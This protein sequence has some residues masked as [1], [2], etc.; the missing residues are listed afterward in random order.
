MKRER[1]YNPKQKKLGRLYNISRFPDLMFGYNRTIM[2][3]NINVLLNI[4]PG[5]GA[6]QPAN[7]RRISGRCF[8]PFHFSYFS[9]GEKRR[10][11]VRLLFAG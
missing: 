9:E 3:T 11:E 1:T 2:R 6:G 7:S 4:G 8:S 10:S 5:A